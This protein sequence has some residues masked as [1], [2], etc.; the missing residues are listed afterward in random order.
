LDHDIESY[1]TPYFDD[2]N[3]LCVLTILCSNQSD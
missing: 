1:I 3:I 2:N